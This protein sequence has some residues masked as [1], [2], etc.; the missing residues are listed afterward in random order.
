MFALPI[1]R[2]THTF[3]VSPSVAERSHG[4]DAGS[5]SRRV[6]TAG[7]LL[8]LLAACSSSNAPASSSDSGAS[9]SS[10][11][12]TSAEAGDAGAASGGQ[13]LLL[14]AAGS[15]VATSRAIQVTTAYAYNVASDTWGEGTVLGDTTHGGVDAVDGTLSFGFMGSTALAL[16]TNAT[17]TASDMWGAAGDVEFA[18]WVAGKW[19]PFAAISS[20]ATGNAP[21]SLVFGASSAVA[22]YATGDTNAESTA[23]FSGSTWSSASAIG[24]GMGGGPSLV[25]RSGGLSVAYVRASDG[26]LVERDQSGSA[27]GAEQVIVAGTDAAPPA[28]VFPPTLVALSG[29]GPDLLLVFTDMAGT[30]L[31][32]A[33]RTG[34]TWSKAQGLG[35]TDGPS[36]QYATQVMPLAGGKAMMAFTSISQNVLVSTFSGTSWS[37][38]TSAFTPWCGDCVD[39]APTALSAGV[40]T[41]SAEI[42]FGGDPSGNN[43]YVP[44]HTRLVNGQWTTPKP[45]V[46]QISGFFAAYALAPH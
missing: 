34:G 18:T 15:A 41:A 31:H 12:S 11:S 26:A 25:M 23:T 8:P 2:T 33:T 45:V 14:I 1:S 3:D 46:A 22:A 20:T 36:P 19:T 30:D 27:W 42:V 5:R 7:V 21:P 43:N 17:S 29:T 9:T 13:T 24:T 39:Q 44:Y 4:R 35:L 38:A 10:D 37:T 6:W 40:G 16:L 28:Q 32:F